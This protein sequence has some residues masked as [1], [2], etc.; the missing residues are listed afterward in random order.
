MTSARATDARMV[1]D[2]RHTQF[3]EYDLPAGSEQT[4]DAV[5]EWLGKKRE[6]A[7]HTKTVLGLLDPVRLG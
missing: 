5:R 4:Q 6:L 2:R 7:K 3:D 1:F